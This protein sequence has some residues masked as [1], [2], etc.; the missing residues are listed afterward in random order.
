MA[1]RRNRYRSERV[2]QRAIIRRSLKAVFCV[3]AFAAVMVLL[4]AGL[5]RV[6]RAVLNLPWLRVEDVQISGCSGWI[7]TKF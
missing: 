7:A 6:Y 3:M 2:R 4:S 5:E 1:R